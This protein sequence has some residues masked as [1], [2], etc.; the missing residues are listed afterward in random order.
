M[1]LSPVQMEAGPTSELP[2]ELGAVLVPEALKSAG[3]MA[4]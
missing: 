2:A 1:E 4:A 3:A